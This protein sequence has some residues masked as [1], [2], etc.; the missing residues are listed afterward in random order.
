VPTGSAIN[1]NKCSSCR[2]DLDARGVAPVASCA[3]SGLSYRTASPPELYP[4]VASSKPTTQAATAL[5]SRTAVPRFPPLADAL[6]AARCRH[7]GRSLRV[8]GPPDPS[9]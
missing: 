9:R 7:E 4:H 8:A 3:R 5:A 6:E 1:N 2:P